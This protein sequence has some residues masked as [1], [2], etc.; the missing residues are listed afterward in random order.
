MP[1]ATSTPAIKPQVK[2]QF[3]QINFKIDIQ[4]LE[5]LRAYAEFI[6]S[7][8]SYVIR[9][10]LNYLF[11]SDFPFQEFFASRLMSE[12]NSNESA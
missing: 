5:K 3:E 8:Q 9:E 10:A 4:T 12:A 11:E 6:D 2:M 7:D 1:K